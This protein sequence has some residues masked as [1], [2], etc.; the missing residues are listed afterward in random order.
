MARRYA[1]VIGISEYNSPLAN[2]TKT[3][4]DAKAVAD[5]LRQ[6]GNLQQPPTLLTGRLTKTQLEQAIER[7]L[8]EQAVNNEALIY[9]TGHGLI[10]K[11]LGAFLVTSDSRLEQQGGEITTLGNCLPLTTLDRLIKQSNFSNLMVLLDCCHSG[12]FLE[13]TVTEG[14]NAFSPQK[15]YYF[16]TA[17]RG[18]ETARARKSEQHS[19][20]TG[21]LLEALSPHNVS[22]T[23]EITGHRLFDLLSDALKD[24]DRNR[25]RSA[26]DAALRSSLTQ[27]NLRQQLASIQPIPT[28]AYRHF[29]LSKRLISMDDRPKCAN[30][31]HA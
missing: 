29:S 26:M 21:A 3:V 20:F 17:C 14:L 7:L 1:L 24:R 8:L 5:R 6:H 12:R 15:D 2:L 9:F 25:F 22:E 31:W 10:V 16:I 18:F 13:R 30:C 19:V 11:D 27:S 4:T 23:G 28:L